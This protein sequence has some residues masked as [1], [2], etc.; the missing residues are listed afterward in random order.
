MVRYDLAILHPDNPRFRRCRTLPWPVLRD[1]GIL[2]GVGVPLVAIERADKSLALIMRP[3]V[4][5]LDDPAIPG[6]ADAAMGRNIDPDRLSAKPWRSWPDL[7]AYQNFADSRSTERCRLRRAD[8]SR[9]SK[10]SSV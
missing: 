9:C 7:G 2:A 6:R 10:K 4:V 5:S 8:T 3:R 1:L